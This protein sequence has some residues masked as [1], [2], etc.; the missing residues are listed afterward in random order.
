M[1]RLLTPVFSP[2]F[3]KQYKKLPLILQKKFTKQLKFL[4]ENSRHPSLRIKKMEG[5]DFFEAR[6]DYHNRFVYKIVVNE[7]RFYAIGPHDE[8][9]GKK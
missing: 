4:V 1:V 2:K 8:G 3:K 9:L 5:T 6:L 7:I